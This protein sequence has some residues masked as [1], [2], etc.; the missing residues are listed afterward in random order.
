M[1]ILPIL[2]V[3]EQPPRAALQAIPFVPF[4]SDRKPT[5]EELFPLPEGVKI[6][7]FKFGNL[8]SRPA[9]SSQDAGH[10]HLSGRSHS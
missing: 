6:H 1:S 8:F 7:H 3:S 2:G 9:T 5:L 10:R 4:N